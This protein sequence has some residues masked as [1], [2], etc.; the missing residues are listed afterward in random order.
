MVS[1][2]RAVDHIETP[3]KEAP[4]IGETEPVTPA[5]QKNHQ[6]VGDPRLTIGQS[7]SSAFQAVR[8][9]TQDDRREGETLVKDDAGEKKSVEPLP[10]QILKL[11]TSFAKMFTVFIENE[12]KLREE[13]SRLQQQM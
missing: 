3:G 5:A 8:P 4:S 7:A 2:L 6:E 10:D 13:V 12:E 9:S 1:V 11:K